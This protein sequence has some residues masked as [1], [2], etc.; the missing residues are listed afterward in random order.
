MAKVH[1]ENANIETITSNAVKSY[2]NL[3]DYIVKMLHSHLE[4]HMKNFIFHC[5]IGADIIY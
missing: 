5:I 4:I 2:A 1:F 3:N